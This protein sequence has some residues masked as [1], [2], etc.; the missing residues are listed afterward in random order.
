MFHYRLHLAQ[1]AKLKERL[2]PIRPSASHPKCSKCGYFA[3]DITD[4]NV[5]QDNHNKELDFLC[6][7]CLEEFRN[8][9]EIQRH[10]EAAHRNSDF[11][12]IERIDLYERLRQEV[13]MTDNLNVKVVL[14][15][16]YSN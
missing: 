12:F 9:Q 8:V 1:H 14:R 4:M 5:H 3:K 15:D 2:S 6:A 16:I 10:I 13:Q 11:R 7:H